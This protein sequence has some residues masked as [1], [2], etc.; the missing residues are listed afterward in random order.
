[1]T[2]R[3]EYGSGLRYR[4]P[5]SLETYTKAEIK[6]KIYNSSFIIQEQKLDHCD[7]TLLK[8][9]MHLLQLKICESG[10]ACKH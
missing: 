4:Y 7:L 10:P 5:Q 3:V 1:M 8:K 2:E 6:K 9:Q